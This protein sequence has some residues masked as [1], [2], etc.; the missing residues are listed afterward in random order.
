MRPRNAGEAHKLVHVLDRIYVTPERVQKRKQ[1]QQSN[2]NSSGQRE[3]AGGGGGPESATASA[4][5]K[6]LFYL[7][8]LLAEV[9]LF[10]TITLTIYW[11][12]N[13]QGGVAW[14]NDTR[15]QFNLHYILMVGG[16]IF[17]NGHAMLVY[18]SFTCCK[19]IYN[20]VLHTIFF[21]L[22]ISAITIGIV[23][24]FQAHN[25]VADPRHFYSLHSWIGLGTMGLFALQFVVGF[26]SFLVLLCCDKA[27]VTYRQRLVPIH[28]NFGLIIFGMAAATCVTGLMQTATY[29]FN[30]KDGAPLYRELPEQGIFVN[31][32]A[33]AII[34]LTILLPLLVKNNLR[35][36]QTV[37]S[38]N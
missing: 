5:M 34:A 31:T 30:G 36:G 23:S 3:A 18:R 38:I 19:K 12:F 8:L 21:V 37:L 26:I 16:F 29:R 14:A 10:G 27:T 13:Y 22:S 15:K 11:I 4:A 20:K 32:I 7:L 33:I 2:N 6:A 24:A 17:L 28:T 1:Q 35:G 25:N 9:L